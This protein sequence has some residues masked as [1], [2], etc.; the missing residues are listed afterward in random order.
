MTYFKDL[1][2]GQRMA[3]LLATVAMVLMAIDPAWAGGK[4][5]SID[6][7]KMGM[8]LFGGLSI[9]LYGMELMTEA[10]RAVAGE[11]MKDI[12]AK[13]TTNRVA[14]V[15]TGA[16]TTAVVQSSSVTTVIV[17]GFVTAGLMNL[18]QAIGVI[19]GAN[20]GTTIT[21]QIVAFKVTKYALLMVTA[22]FGMS[23]LSK[24]DKIK[25]WGLMLLGLG[26]VFFGMKVMSGA[27]KPL[28]SYQPFLDMMTQ[29]ENP[30]FG[31]LLSAGFTGLI[32]SSSAT[33][34]IVIVMA[35]QGLITLPAG[36][37]LSFGANI[38]TCVTA[39][40]ACIGKSREAV[41][42]AVA[43]M[44]FNVL[45]VIIWVAFIPQLIE[46]VTWLSPAADS[47]LTGKDKLA[48]EAP[49]QIA[50]A[51][52]VFNVSNT[53]LFLP[54]TGVFATIVRKLVP[55]KVVTAAEEAQSGFK[56]KYLD[57]G[58]LST[59][60]L[61]LSMV[62]REA[63]RMGWVIE[64]MLNGAPE[65]VFKGNL[66]HMTTIREMD[67]QA[68]VLYGEISK[69]LANIGRQNLTEK[70]AAEAMSS[71]TTVTEL[72][73]IGDIIETH[74]YHITE[75]HAKSDIKLDDEAVSVLTGYHEMVAKAFQ[76]SMVAWEHERP[77]AAKIV[78]KMEEEVV[79]SMDA[80]LD[81]RHM[82]LVKGEKSAD[83]MAAFTML[84][85][86]LENYKRIYMH[87]KRIAKLILHQEGSTAL[88]S[89]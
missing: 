4:T 88:V 80:Y 59:P 41:Q 20:I 22:G 1:K 43:H 66:D 19:F 77:D 38:G 89:V 55:E 62:R 84:S 10:L 28:R 14:G 64:Q 54:F 21:A 12:L 8:T 60:P 49:R 6:W 29:M 57:E 34:S 72:E 87:T 63:R 44:M 23:M 67:D 27:M 83:E 85:D 69:Y 51:H 70:S 71:M 25:S 56:P 61:A 40:L 11:K 50:N 7:F 75:V 15:F 78:L 65:G 52:T 45:G 16:L 81:E 31:I 36:I 3:L 9:F 73:N 13:M 33:T 26:L 58:M 53:L 35:T 30:V 86:I 39:L 18:S 82:E 79:D 68:D 37:A 42:A 24:D 76:S 2:N 17:V 74:L 47:T 46:F 48:A 32:Q 5:K